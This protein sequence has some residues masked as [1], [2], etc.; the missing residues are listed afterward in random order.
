MTPGHF[1]FF[2]I[3]QFV[4]S[5]LGVF[6]GCRIV[7]QYILDLKYA[8]FEETDEPRRFVAWSNMR[9]ECLVLFSQ[10]CFL[11][12]GLSY[13]VYPFPSPDIPIVQFRQVMLL[14]VTMALAAKSFILMRDRRL[15]VDLLSK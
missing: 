6:F 13:Y 3:A 9:R 11:S 7:Y 8:N 12:V 2:E 1:H 4:F 10:V 15:L 5:L 14:V